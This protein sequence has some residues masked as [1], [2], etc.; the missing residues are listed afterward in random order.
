[1][2]CLETLLQ[3]RVL[4]LH[5]RRLQNVGTNGLNETEKNRA[6]FLFFEGKGVS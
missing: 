6:L 5:G 4:I 1:M 2:T 3:V